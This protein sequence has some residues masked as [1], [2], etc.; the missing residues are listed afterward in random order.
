MIKVEDTSTVDIDLWEKYHQSLGPEI[1]LSTC[2]FGNYKQKQ[3]EEDIH[4]RAIINHT[5]GYKFKK[6][7]TYYFAAN[8]WWEQKK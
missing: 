8:K 4:L 2:S 5:K 1:I 3:V 7:K 6:G